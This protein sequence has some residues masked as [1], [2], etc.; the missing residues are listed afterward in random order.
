M[1]YHYL[2]A[3]VLLHA[4]TG[5]ELLAMLAVALIMEAAPNTYLVLSVLGLFPILTQLDARSRFQEYKKVRDQLI[6]YGPDRRIFKSMAA[7]RCQRDAAMAAA[8]QLGCA[9]DG[10]AFFTA[11]GYRWYHLVPEFALRHSAFL[12]QAAFWRETFFV[13]TYHAR[14]PFSGGSRMALPGFF[15][16]VGAS[17]KHSWPFFLAV[18]AI[19]SVVASRSLAY[20][21]VEDLVDMVATDQVFTAVIDGRREFTEN[22]RPDETIAWQGAKGEIGAFLTTER[23]LAVTITSGRWNTQPL[24]VNEKRNS[25]RI[26]LG[27][28][29]LVMLSDERL[30]GFGTQTSGFFQVRRP[31]GERIVAEAIEGRVAAVIMPSRAF[32][33]SSNRRGAAEIRFR[34]LERFETLKTTYNK[35]TLKTSQR[36]ITLT[37]R[38]TVWRDFELK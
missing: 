38:D 5:I 15:R 33:F 31:L 26:L 17:V 13:P 9:A 19:L 7:S 30:V 10:S 1:A 21:E 25:P 2:S 23:L 35:I 22:R 24:K 3:G 8:R 14:H 32:G 27:K 11:A 37:S 12:L 20:E 16:T 18:I 4:I 34:R 36:L 29:L 28:H 6:R